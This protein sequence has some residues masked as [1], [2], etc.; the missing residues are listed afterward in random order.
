MSNTNI[1]KFNPIQSSDLNCS[2]FVFEQNGGQ[3]LT[4]PSNRNSLHLIADGVGVF[5]CEGKDHTVE[6]GTMFF[7]KRGESF[8]VSGDGLK[9]YY[10]RFEGR[11]GDEIL[12]RLGVNKS[13]RVFCG[14]GE[15]LS[16]WEGCLSSSDES[17]LDLLAESV[18]LYSMARLSPKKT[19]KSDMVSRVI[20]ITADRFTY[21]SL[22]LSSIS[23]EIGYHEKYVSSRFKKE[24]GISFVQYLRNIRIDHAVFL[25]EQGVVSVKNVA[26]LSGFS[27]SLYFSKVFKEIKGVSPKE[28]I[29]HLELL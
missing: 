18:L 28:F 25:M 23:A 19:D 21:P 16:F 14:F 5:S 17:N 1:C 15:L 13:N 3:S 9:Y 8:S 11:R 22:S 27:D 7:V 24:M 4:S 20:A 12:S 2:A 10:I 29:T 6:P 26:L